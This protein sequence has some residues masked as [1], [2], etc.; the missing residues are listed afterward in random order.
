MKFASL[1]RSI[2][3]EKHYEVD[4]KAGAV[5][6]SDKGMDFVEKSLGVKNI[7]EDAQLAYHLDNALKAKELYK[8]DDEYMVRDGEVMIVDEFT[9]RALSGRRY[10]EGLHQAIEA[11][12]GVEVKRESRTMATITLQNYF[13][14]YKYL[15]GMTATALTEAEEFASIYHLDTIVVPT[16]EP[17]IRKDYTDI[18][19]KTQEGK[20]KAI[21][22]DIKEHHAKDQPILVGTTSVEKSEIISEMLNKDGIN[23]EVFKCKTS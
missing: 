14:L 15:S 19:Y 11:K 22:E 6:L 12:E 23:H 18:V 21:V 2:Q 1:A 10:S 20:F 7:Y 8:R 16:N 17:V 9:G 3:P 5:S 13:R 4:E